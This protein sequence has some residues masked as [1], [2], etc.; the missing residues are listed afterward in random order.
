VKS[1]A[2]GVA[3]WSV[4]ATS[5]IAT[6]ARGLGCS[7]SGESC[8]CSG[9]I[10]KPACHGSLRHRLAQRACACCVLR[11][12]LH[13]C[14]VCSQGIIFDSTN[15]APSNL[16]RAVKRG[17]GP[18]CWTGVTTTN[19]V[20]AQEMFSHS[21]SPPATSRFT[22]GSCGV[23]SCITCD[24]PFGASAMTSSSRSLEAFSVVA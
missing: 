18:C 20:L 12:T 13:S 1:V 9:K 14:P 22:S 24:W 19:A 15:T 16:I 5:V 3:K 11:R 23:S 21:S 4:V 2:R 17:C 7:G 8:A 6:C 10:R